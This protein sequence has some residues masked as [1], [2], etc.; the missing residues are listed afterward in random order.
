MATF[1]PNERFAFVGKTRSGKT[2]LGM[3][4]AG[5]LAMA[6][7]NTT[8]QVWVLTTKGDPNDLVGWRKWGARNI[9]S[10]R[11]QASTIVRNFFYFRI[12]PKDAQGNDVSVAGQCQAIIDAAYRRGQVVIVID[13]YVS[14]VES[15]RNAGKSL[16]DVF[17]RGGG[18]TVGLIGMTQE[19]VYIPR[20]LISMATHAFIFTLTHRYD[21]EWAQKLYKTYVPPATRGDPHGF[22]YKW[23]DGPTNKWQYFAHQKA[24][25]DDLRIAMPQPPPLTETALKTEMW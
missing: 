21:I 11:D 3:V 24:W 5:T 15:A 7:I 9:A 1:H 13:E 20:Q 4:V 25:Y 16:L 10:K 19:P 6:L 22:Y 14:V 17:Q 12:E 23:V 2:S 8:W 18:L